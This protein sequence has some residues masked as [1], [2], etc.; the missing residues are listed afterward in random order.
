MVFRGRGDSFG[1]PVTCGL[2]DR[3]VGDGAGITSRKG[4]TVESRGDRF[5]IVFL[6]TPD[7]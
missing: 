5:L 4:Y 1:T 6:L 2:P 7:S 3:R